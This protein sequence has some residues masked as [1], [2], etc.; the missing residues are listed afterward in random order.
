MVD[1]QTPHHVKNEYLQKLKH[2]QIVCVI[3]RNLMPKIQ[4]KR[5]LFSILLNVYYIASNACRI[6]Q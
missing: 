2:L 4:Q 1:Q 6:M 5:F 3:G